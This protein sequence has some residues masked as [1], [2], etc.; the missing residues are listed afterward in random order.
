MTYTTN[1]S[2]S[3]FDI[4]IIG[5][6]IQGV[7]IA[8]AAAAAGYKTLL[9]EKTDLAAGTSSK[10]SKLIH[11]GLR[12]L[13]SG[14]FGLVR[15]SLKERELLLKNAPELVKS[16]WFYITIYRHSRYRPW[17]IR[18]GL[19]LYWL[20]TG[21]KDAGKF[22][23]VPSSDWSLLDNINTAKLQKVFRYRDAQTDD[24]LLTQAVAESAQSLGAT[25]LCP[26]EFQS[27]EKNNTGYR[28]YYRDSSGKQ[29]VSCRFLINAGGPWV[30]HLQACI[31][32][33]PATPQIDLVQGTH[34][35]L[36]NQ[37]SDKCFYLESPK[38]GRAVFALP[39]YGKTLLGTTETLHHGIPEQSSPT[40]LERQYLL[41]VLKHYFPDYQ[42]N[43]VEE[44]SGLR[45][46]PWDK[47]HPFHRSREVQLVPDD[48]DHPH[49]LAI[50][51]GKL[52]G[53]RATAEKVLAIVTRTLG[54]KT[55]IADTKQLKLALSKT[56]RTRKDVE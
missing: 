17:K 49:Y 6:G 43:I 33:T 48:I 19:F 15:E 54:A 39:W 32:P 31:S 35:I 26:A 51:G 7:G 13:Q 20:L 3:D 24:K 42:G 34:L 38:D 30:H 18:T 52:T 29:S 44:M 27:A 45:V 12:Y 46:L 28:V 1:T 37:L 53:Y 11:G 2:D 47:A 16:R 50:F 22:E 5:G 9:L 55:A 56:C 14:Q 36:K 4:A 41:D 23:T 21:F 40:T 8:Q 25:L 10:S